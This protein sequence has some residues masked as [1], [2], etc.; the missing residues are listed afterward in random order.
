MELNEVKEYIEKNLKGF[1]P[2]EYKDYDIAFKKTFKTNR[3]V[4]AFT[5]VNP[6]ERNQAAP[7]M[8]VDDVLSAYNDGLSLDEALENRA[9]V[10][11][12]SMGKRPA[13]LVTSVMN[14][15]H[16]TANVVLTVINAKENE[17]ML[18]GC[19]HR[20][21][22]DLAVTYSWVLKSDK[23]G[24]YTNRITNELCEKYGIDEEFLFE[25]AKENTLR[26]MPFRV[27]NITEVIG[28]LVF[29]EKIDTDKELKEE[30]NDF[31]EDI[32]EER[33]MYVVTN[34]LNM[35]G[36]NALLYPEE[37]A[38]LATRFDCDL[39][40]IPS[41]TH[42]LI[43]V[44]SKFGDAET[45]AEMVYEVNMN[46]VELGERLSNEVYFYDRAKREIYRATDVPNKSLS[47]VAAEKTIN[48]ETHKAPVR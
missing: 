41:S 32:P 22:E 40:I 6:T 14:L 16:L 26:I 38:D 42:E 37:F 9:K 25:H 21:F 3:E 43:A 13:D 30:F 27:R 44:P 29:G 28:N 10:I 19:P 33:S 47:A 18:K 2:D 24:L 45:L 15:E 39:Y 36:S 35:F 46:E 11:V 34:K 7:T 12:D 8:Y 20:N 17:E 31:M 1:L 23:E 48:Y 4:L 5:L